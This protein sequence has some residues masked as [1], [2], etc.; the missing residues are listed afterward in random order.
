MEAPKAKKKPRRTHAFGGCG[1]CRR[2]HVKCD[3]VRPVCLTCQAVGAICDGFRTEL[4]WV[5]ESHGTGAKETVSQDLT[6]HTVRNHLFSAEQSR[7][8]MSKALQDDLGRKP[9]DESLSE[10]EDRC[11][12]AVAGSGKDVAIGPFGVF[13]LQQRAAEPEKQETPTSITDQNCLT[14]SDTDFAQSV[15]FVDSLNMNDFLD[16]PDLFDLDLPEN[17]FLPQN[18]EEDIAN[19]AY[20]ETSGLLSRGTPLRGLEENPVQHEGALNDTRLSSPK[21][22]DASTRNELVDNGINYADVQILLKHFNDQVIAHMWAAPVTRKSPWELMNVDS[23]V[24]TLARLTYM[25]S[26]TL[27]H[28]ALSNLFALTA[29]SANHLAAQLCKEPDSAASVEHWQHLAIVTIKEAKRHLQWSL[30]NEVRGPHKAKYKDQLMAIIAMLSFSILYD[31]QPD[32]RAYMIDA[33]RLLRLRGLAKRNISRKARLLHH[34]YT[35]ARIVDESTYVLRSYDNLDLETVLPRRFKASTATDQAIAEPRP[36]H[37]PRLDDFLRLE[38]NAHDLDR[39]PEGPK[40]HEIGLHDI[41]LE[42]TREFSEELFAQL[43]GVSETWLSLVSRTTRLANIMDAVSVAKKRQEFVHLEWLETQKH[44]LENMV[45]SFASTGRQNGQNTAPHPRDHMVRAL[46]SAL[47]IFFYRR[48]RNVNPWILQEHVKNVTQALKDFDAACQ[49][50]NIDAPG[51][52]WPAFMA[53]CEA[54]SQ[55]QRIYFSDWFDRSISTTGFPR[56]V[57]AKHCM[58]EVWKLQDASI[59][60]RQRKGMNQI[61]SWVEVSKQENLHMLLS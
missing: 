32:A 19:A 45:C 55:E 10:L 40:E 9:V 59:Q 41:H 44:R 34:V 51:S 12:N 1:T 5:S 31:K 30:R 26:Q 4:K 17:D 22:V 18:F 48:I 29:T 25:T 49:S 56:L 33:E 24:I 2:R 53:G 35:W 6:S 14:C 7:K 58:T 27:S 46:N 39:E 21:P 57:K 23:A 61:N 54:L 8:S 37:N 16:W 11:K 52:P 13:Q 60:S 38:H 36:S 3:Q 50:S 20:L 28:A 47:V 42:D 43:Y 15:G